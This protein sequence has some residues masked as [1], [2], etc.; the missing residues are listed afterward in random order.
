MKFKNKCFQP[1]LSDWMLG[2]HHEIKGLDFGLRE[3][4]EY[5]KN[6]LLK[7]GTK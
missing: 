6:L 7:T 4:F 1:R 3:M 2:K 5:K